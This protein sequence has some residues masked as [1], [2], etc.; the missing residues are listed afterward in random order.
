MTTRAVYPGTFDP[1]TN[2]HVALVRRAA[3]LFDTVIVA[4]AETARKNPAFSFEQ[5]IA[6]AE[7][8][9]DGIDN[10][11]VVSFGGLLVEFVRIHGVKII[12][13]GLRAVS[14]FD[15]EFQLA[16]MNHQMAPEV[17]TVFLPALG[18]TAYISGTMVREIMNLGGDP[19]EFVPSVV[20]DYLQKL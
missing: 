3:T 1:V 10:V 18:E 16:G 7:S 20:M 17:E 2:G 15:Y 5:R 19:S 12:I 8:S 4:V 9:L 6:M 13:R 11:E 14:D